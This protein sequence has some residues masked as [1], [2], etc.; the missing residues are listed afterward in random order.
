M[1][2]RSE[3]NACDCVEV[4]PDEIVKYDYNL[5]PSLYYKM[6]FDL[7]EGQQVMRIS[8]LL[9]PVEG[10]RISAR[11]VAEMVSI[12]NLSK[13]FIEVLLNNGKQSAPSEVRRNSNCRVFKASDSKYL[14]A[15]SNAGESR[16]GINTDGKGFNCTADIKVYKVNESL[17][18]PEYIAYTLINNDAISKGRMPLSGYMMHPIV[19]DSLPDRKSVV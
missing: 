9:E 11:D 18:S 7:K 16:Y 19:I 1:L 10:E 3:G 5:N 17:V 2:F 12:S 15:F 6:D 13:D 4:S 14:F 8:E